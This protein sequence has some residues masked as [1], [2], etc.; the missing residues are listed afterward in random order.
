LCQITSTAISHSAAA[1]Q[2]EAYSYADLRPHI[3]SLGN[4]GMLRTDGTYGTSKEEVQAIFEQDIPR[5]MEPWGEKHL[6]LYAHGGLVGE[7]ATVQRLADYRPALLNANV[8]PISF[9]WHSDYWTTVTNILQDAIRRRRPEG[10][11]DLTKDFMLDRLDDALEPLARTL[12]GKAE[13]DEMKENALD[14][15]TSAQ[16]GVRF[17]LDLIAALLQ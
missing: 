16:G 14:A 2:S 11:L 15:T 3:I 1:G 5:V 10:F 7:D 13:W 17:T 6:L 9:I 12:T 4:N 8:Y